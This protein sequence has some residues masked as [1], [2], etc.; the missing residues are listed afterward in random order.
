MICRSLKEIQYLYGFSST[1]S[2][3][4]PQLP[5]IQE[6]FSGKTELRVYVGRTLPFYPLKPDCLARKVIVATHL[7]LLQ[8]RLLLTARDWTRVVTGPHR[9]VR[10][11]YRITVLCV[12]G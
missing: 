9:M 2:S 7:H 12:G 11:F 6:E 4:P 10:Q 1:L 3:A 5:R 8:E